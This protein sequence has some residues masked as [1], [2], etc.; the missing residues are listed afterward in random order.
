MIRESINEKNVTQYFSIIRQRA[1]FLCNLR[2]VKKKIYENWSG[3]V[4]DY[5]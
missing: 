4:D 2:I 5:N 1:S 3:D